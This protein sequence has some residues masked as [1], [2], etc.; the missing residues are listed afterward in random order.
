MR[1]QRA[2]TLPELLIGVT[3][4]AIVMVG[5]SVFVASGIGDAFRIR[6][7][8]DDNRESLEFETELNRMTAF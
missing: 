7:T 6:K 4:S 3:V 2:F 5:V 1:S 8:I